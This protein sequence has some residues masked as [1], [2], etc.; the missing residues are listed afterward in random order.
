MGG[1]EG[2]DHINLHGVPLDMVQ[3]TGHAA[4]WEA[5]YA[6]AR[7]V[8]MHT[9]RESVGWRI[10]APVAARQMEFSRLDTAADAAQRQGMQVIWSLMHYGMPPDVRVTDADF[11][12]RF[13]DFAAAVARRLRGRSAA[14]PVYNPINEIGFLAWA[15]ATQSTLGGECSE[16]DG[17]VV[18]MALVQAA[19]RGMQAMRA[20]D[21]SARFMHI[22]P[23]IHVVAPHGQPEL[24]PAASDFCA[25]Q[26]QVWDMLLGRSEPQLGGAAAMV[27]CIGV[28]HYHDAQW[29]IGTGERLKWEEN[30]GR[31]RPFA[32]LLQQAWA[33]YG[34]PL[35]V[36]ETSHCADKR[37]A[38][39]NEIAAQTAAAMAS[40]VGVEGLCLYPL[41][42]RPG[43]N[44][45]AH[46]HRS[47][48]W[49]AIDTGPET[50]APWARRLASD[51]ARALGHWQRQLPG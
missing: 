18:K 46:W 20:E 23:L 17:Y 47:G 10:C 41:V 3:V 27:D 7:S 49:D 1:F 9:V 45:L 22:E 24:A 16:R 38:W 44:E 35:V 21:P 19:V 30:D 25:Y 31:R 42:D 48:L 5:D 28:N 37:A 13:A 50:A 32:Q 15:L 34:I 8:G 4:Q 29:E 39:L 2:A 51:Y 11:A 12:D 36:A 26:W 43:W 40:G 33:R 6:L 14:A